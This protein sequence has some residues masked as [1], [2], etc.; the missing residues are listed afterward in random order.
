MDAETCRAWHTAGEATSV[1]GSEYHPIVQTGLG[2]K[3]VQKRVM[4]LIRYLVE[5]GDGSAVSCR[6]CSVTALIQ[7]NHLM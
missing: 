3:F 4:L 6:Q 2:T 7:Y 5:A 1:S